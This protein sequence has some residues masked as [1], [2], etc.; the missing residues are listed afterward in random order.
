MQHYTCPNITNKCSPQRNILQRLPWGFLQ[1]VTWFYIGYLFCEKQQKTHELPEWFKLSANCVH[2]YEPQPAKASSLDHISL[3][4]CLESCSD[5]E[6]KI[7]MHLLHWRSTCACTVEYC[8]DIWPS[9]KGA[10][11]AIKTPYDVCLSAARLLSCK[12]L[13]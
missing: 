7:T 8:N 13:L 5:Y 11:R 12:A 9:R 2:I 3:G 1:C 10:I 6:R 4:Q